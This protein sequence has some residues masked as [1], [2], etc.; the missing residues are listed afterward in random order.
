MPEWI[1]V[2]VGDISAAQFLF[3][4]VAVILL[5]GAVIKLWPFVKNAVAIVDALVDLPAFIDRT[6]ER[7]KDIHHET[8]LNN[9]S[10]IKDS[11]IRTEL[12][13]ERVELGVKGLYART[14]E[15]SS[16]H[17]VLQEK[18]ETTQPRRRA[19][20]QKDEV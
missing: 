14:D 5:L 10:S 8:H 18:F 3:W 17:A 16:A 15:L 19:P 9:G 1:T 11:T 13:V 2:L 12:A 4:I 6:D 7:I 20:K